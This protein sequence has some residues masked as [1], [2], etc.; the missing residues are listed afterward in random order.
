MSAAELSVNDELVERV[1]WAMWVH[2]PMTLGLHWK[3]ALPSVRDQYRRMAMGAIAK[4]REHDRNEA[5]A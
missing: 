3:H 4:V 2:D 5:V 1:A